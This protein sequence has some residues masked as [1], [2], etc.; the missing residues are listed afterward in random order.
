MTT[1]GYF[2]TDRKLASLVH[3]AMRRCCE[4]N[5]K[6]YRYYGYRGVKFNFNSVPEAI[7]YIK[8]NLPPRQTGETLDRTNNMGHYEP[9]NI[10]WAQ[11]S[12]QNK[13][14]RKRLQFFK[15]DIQQFCSA[16][17]ITEECF[18]SAYKALNYVSRT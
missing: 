14:K 7:E 9:G 12:Q 6:E 15:D 8:N 13:N 5:C 2:K 18:E 3:N 10:T 11:R 17:G 16:A 1:H 4:P